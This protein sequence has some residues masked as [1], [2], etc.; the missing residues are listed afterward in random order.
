[1]LFTELGLGQI[2]SPK[3][4][5]VGALV[6]AGSAPDFVNPREL[7]TKQLAEYDLRGSSPTS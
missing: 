6:L 5:L 4:Q 1:M 2:R 3:L 7:K